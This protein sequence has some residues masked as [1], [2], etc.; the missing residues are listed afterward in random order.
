MEELNFIELFHGVTQP[1]IDRMLCCFETQKLHFQKGQVLMT[2]QD[3]L[4]KIGILLSGRAHLYCIDYDGSYMLLERFDKNDL[5]GEP[6]SLPLANLEYIVEGDT[7]CEVLFIPYKSIIK[8]CENACQHH[9]QLVDNLFHLATRKSQALSLRVNLL[10]TKTI[11]QKLL[12]YFM[13][14]Q[15]KTGSNTFRIDMSLTELAAYLCVDRSSMMRE[16]RF[17][18][19]EG[20]MDSKGRTITLIS[21]ETF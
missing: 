11:R 12:N 19:E 4:Q 5:F 3:N 16:I 20:L 6:F 2:Y 18:K 13:W 9:T 21:T 17:M 8:R 7:D 10:S 14:M 15:N 1:E